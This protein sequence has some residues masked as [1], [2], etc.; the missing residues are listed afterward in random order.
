MIQSNMSCSCLDIRMQ[1]VYLLFA[2]NM[3]SVQD[4]HIKNEY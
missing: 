2:D 4:N 3:G 1:N